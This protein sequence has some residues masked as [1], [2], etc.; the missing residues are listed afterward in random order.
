MAEEERIWTPGYFTADDG[1]RGFV[2]NDGRVSVDGKTI[3]YILPDGTIKGDGGIYLGRLTKDGTVYE[4]GGAVAGNIHKL[5]GNGEIGR[6]AYNLSGSRE[7]NPS[8]E[9]AK[10]LLGGLAF[11]AK[12]G[13]PLLLLSL[14]IGL[15]LLGM[16]FGLSALSKA[17]GLA[18]RWWIA[19]LTIGSG[20]LLWGSAVR[21][22]RPSLA[23]RLKW[24][25]F[26]LLGITLLYLS[27]FKLGLG[28]VWA[29]P[30]DFMTSGGMRGELM[31]F[32]SRCPAMVRVY[33]WFIRLVNSSDKVILNHSL[34]GIFDTVESVNLAMM[35]RLPVLP[36]VA[37]ALVNTLLV[38][39][40]V[41]LMIPLLPLCCLAT[42]F[43]P[44]ILLLILLNRLLF[45]D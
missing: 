22:S 3:A 26:P 4:F 12:K 25:G 21:V 24:M 27:I 37:L 41:I 33:E 29:F 13:I 5:G 44:P 34:Q 30:L 18:D 7:E 9:I 20:L 43:L 32:I 8:T 38:T 15:V 14:P 10:D 36:G 19:A 40:L 31:G 16:Y 1:S 2:E 11:L 17:G 28:A 23:Q 42:P 35:S 6:F 45:P 39:A